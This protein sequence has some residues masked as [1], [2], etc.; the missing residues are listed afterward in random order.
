MING[1][2]KEHGILN[3]LMESEYE[4]HLTGSQFFCGSGRDVDYFVQT[5]NPSYLAAWLRTLGFKGTLDAHYKDAN[6]IE[7]MRYSGLFQIDIQFVKDA[8]LKLRIQNKFKAMAILN[9]STNEWDL[10]F[11]IMS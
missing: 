11:K 3:S 8:E 10:A 4:F 2:V 1:Y 7:V 5:N 6:C 9:P